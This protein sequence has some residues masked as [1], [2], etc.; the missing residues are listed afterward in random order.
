MKHTSSEIMANHSL[1]E[2]LLQNENLHDSRQ[3]SEKT[4]KDASRE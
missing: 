4:Q 3:I 1:F 2:I